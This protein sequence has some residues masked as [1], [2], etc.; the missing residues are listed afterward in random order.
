MQYFA[1]NGKIF[2]LFTVP[3]WS[4]DTFGPFLNRDHYASF[5]ALILPMA[6]LRAFDDPRRRLTYILAAA[7][8]YASV[9]A[10][11][12]RAGALLVTAEILLCLF[13]V[14]IRPGEQASAWH[15]HRLSLAAVFLV[16]ALVAVVG[17]EPLWN[18]FGEKDPYRGRREYAIASLS[19]IRERPLTGFGLGSWNTVYPAHAIFDEGLW[20]NAAHSDWLQWACDGG[21]PFAIVFFILFCSSLAVC[22]RVP[23]AIGIP[24]VFIHC[25]VD[26]PIEGGRYIAAM[27][28]LVFGAAVG[29]AAK[30]TNERMP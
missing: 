30:K 12:S 18:R 13:L 22:W 4:G 3:P 29:R 5:I 20:A 7:A 15:R 9:I 19:M 1:G 26:F 2:W 27:F 6:V 14:T 11:Q 28:F 25:T 16:A 17:W 23:W 21:I 10:C 24:A 8:M